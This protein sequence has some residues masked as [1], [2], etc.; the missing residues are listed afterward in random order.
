MYVKSITWTDWNGTVRTEDFYFNLTRT[1]LTKMELKY[2]GG[3]VA[4]VNKLV[5]S[6]D[7]QKILTIFDDIIMTSYGEKSADGKRFVKENGALAKAFA[8]TG[9]YDALFTELI[10]VEGAASKFIKGIM[11]KDINVQATAAPNAPLA[12]PMPTHE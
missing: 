6:E 7:N 11:P 2:E 4:S 10:S 9:A 12:I 8:E 5:K 3:L 1:E